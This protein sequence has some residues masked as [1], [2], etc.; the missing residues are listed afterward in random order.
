MLVQV[1]ISKGH[2]MFTLL[3][4]A[5]KVAKHMDV[6]HSSVSL[7][8]VERFLVFCQLHQGLNNVPLEYC[9]HLAVTLVHKYLS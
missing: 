1:A 5:I 7:C 6:G 4:F 9:M 2:P 3:H 8:C